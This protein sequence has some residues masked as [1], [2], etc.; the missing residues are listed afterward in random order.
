M[1]QV[2]RSGKGGQK[3][4]AREMQSPL[5]LCCCAT[6]L[7]PVFIPQLLLVLGLPNVHLLLLGNN[8]RVPSIAQR[9]YAVNVVVDRKSALEGKVVGSFLKSSCLLSLAARVHMYR[10]L[11][12][13]RRT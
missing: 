11:R 7:F 10:D 13:V 8:T 1:K 6:S 4:K 2:S 3:Q 9:L 12:F 5:L